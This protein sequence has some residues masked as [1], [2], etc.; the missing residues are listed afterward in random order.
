M[1][2]IRIASSMPVFDPR[3]YGLTGA[4]T[5]LTLEGSAMFYSEV[6]SLLDERK[7]AWAVFGTQLN[8]QCDSAPIKS[9]LTTTWK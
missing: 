2:P 1:K 8:N 4:T 6:G 7:R 9:T 3:T 5:R